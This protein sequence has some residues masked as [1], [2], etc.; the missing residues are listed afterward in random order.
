MAPFQ[1]P[2]PFSVRA[3]SMAGIATPWTATADAFAAP[4][5]VSIPPAFGG[6]APGF[7]PEDLYALALE[8]CFIATFKVFAEKSNLHYDT[9]SVSATLW[10]DQMPAGGLGMAR[11]SI[12]VALA[13][14]RNSD[15]ANRVLE[16]TSRGCMIL[17]SVKTEKTFTFTIQSQHVGATSPELNQ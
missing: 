5:T 1:T 12:D 2:L 8:N 6:S 10:V 14:V 17:N 15:L 3:E 11:V 4:I 16:K 7:S 13:G 9:L